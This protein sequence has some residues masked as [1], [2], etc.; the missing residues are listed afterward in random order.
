VRVVLLVAVPAAAFGQ[1]L[2]DSI[3]GCGGVPPQTTISVGPSNYLAALAGLQPGERLLLAP[4]T[5]TGGLPID[6]LNGALNNCIVIEGPDAGPPAVF[7]GRDCCNTISIRNSSYLAIRNLELDGQ[8][9]LGD[10]VKA[11][12]NVSPTHHITLENLYI[13]G[14]G[15]DQ[16][17][18]GINTKSAAWNWVVR[19]SVIEGAGTGIYFGDSD[20]NQE[21]VGGL[22]E[23]NLIRDT[24]GYNMQIKHQNGRVSGAPANGTTII[25]HNVFSKA[26]GASTGSAARPNLLVGHWPLSGTGAN[27]TYLI[28][29]NFFYQNPVEA[30]F[31]GEG[32]VA[33]YD[34]LFLNDFAPSVFP[35]IAIQP[36][37]DVPKAIEVFH[38]TVVAAGPG[39]LVTGG[40]AGF[41]QRVRANAVFSASPAILG[42]NAFDNVT[43]SRAAAISF[44]VNPFGTIGDGL[45]LFPLTGTLSGPPVDTTG[46][47]GF[48]DWDL[49]FN[50]HPRDATFRGAYS[51]EGSN[52]GWPPALERKPEPAPPPVDLAVNDA[53]VAEGGTGAR[54]TVFTVTLSA[55]SSQTVTV[56]Y[57]TSDGTATE[58]IDYLPGLGTIAFPPGTISKTLIVTIIGDRIF[59]PDETF[60][61]NLSNPVN[62]TLVDDQGLGI[63]TN[64]DAQGLSIDD[65]T[66]T[67][68][69]TGTVAAVFTVT[70]APTSGSTVNVNYTTVDDTATS[71]G[72]FQA[73]SGTVEFSP[74]ASTQPISVLVSSD[75]VP[76][77]IETFF[78]DLTSSS[79]AA[80]A[81]ARG[82]GTIFDP[83]AFFT[84]TPCRLIDTRNPDGPLGGPALVA[85]TILAAPRF[86]SSRQ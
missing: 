20:G 5:Y 21:F 72:D 9:R 56:D 80:I 12:F 24:I 42:G 69:P 38:N 68:P 81:H 63:I 39:I 8:G 46:L 48:L 33:L 52:P 15:A 3:G 66:V 49:D 59:E 65:V 17:I 27:D 60:F 71:P 37:N 51:G 7:P 58:G 43:G 74:G 13:H 19:R 26:Q 61:V 22:I 25:R 40:A 29:G 2:A 79:G 44:L 11:E 32:N 84:L 86:R 45:D 55:A 16:Q 64:D 76:D 1:T 57:Q 10:G 75:A 18:V 82:T 70:L 14:H 78:V 30:L 73:D 41:Q 23:H 67:E 83:G 50:G 34:N 77:G 62:G 85:N 54:S 31:Q 6:G 53:A 47:T 36:H 28:Y 4:G 35:A